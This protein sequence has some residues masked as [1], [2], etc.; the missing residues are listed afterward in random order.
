[1]S[2][3]TVQYPRIDYLDDFDEQVGPYTVIGYLTPDVCPCDPTKEWDGNGEIH[4]HPRSRYGRRDSDYYSIL[5]LNGYGDPDLASDA[6]FR[7]AG[8]IYDEWLDKVT[9]EVMLNLLQDLKCWDEDDDLVEISLEVIKTLRGWDPEPEWVVD[10][11]LYNAIGADV[12]R[13]DICQ[14]AD[15]NDFPDFKID[16]DQCWRDARSAGEVG[17]KD[18]V[19]LDLYEHGGMSYSI[20]GQGMNCPWDTSRGVAVWVPDGCARDE[21]DRRAEV[22]AHGQIE[23]E[24]YGR[25]RTFVVTLDYCGTKSPNLRGWS[26]AF[27][28]LKDHAFGE[29][30]ATLGRQRAVVEIAEECLIT[31]NAYVNG[32]V[33]GLCIETYRNYG[34]DNEE[35]VDEEACFGHYTS[36]YAEEALYYEFQ[37]AVEGV[38]KRLATEELPFEAL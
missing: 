11:Y 25:H 22:Y 10:D 6:V 18:A 23:S 26:D 15:D 5:G 13:A 17:D 30:D 38:K 32:D 4:H 37:S 27:E 1:M 36:G 21:I 29:G 16:W 28:W 9:P 24:G 35:L 3:G 20:I 34:Q 12:S 33:Y 2:I 14:A 31:Y 7:R 8:K 19:L